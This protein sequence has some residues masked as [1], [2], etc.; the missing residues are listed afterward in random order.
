MAPDRGFIG[1]QEIRSVFDDFKK[2]YAASLVLIGRDDNGVGGEYSG[3]L[4]RALVETQD[5]AGAT[6]IVAIPLFRSMSDPILQ[7]VIAYLPTYPDAGNIEWTAPM[8]ESYL[9]GQ[10]LLDRVEAGVQP[11]FGAGTP[12]RHRHRRDG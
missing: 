10:I 3:Y 9:V 2:S 4:S 7:K 5:R 1:N 11:G 12:H 8:P 6:H